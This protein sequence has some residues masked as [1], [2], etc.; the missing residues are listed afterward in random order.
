MT[1]GEREHAAPIYEIQQRFGC[2]LWLR[3]AR[4]R[5]YLVLAPALIPYRLA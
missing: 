4:R 5:L 3:L 2:G 1:G